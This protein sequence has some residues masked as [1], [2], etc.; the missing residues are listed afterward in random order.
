MD[1]KV[2]AGKYRVER[3]LSQEQAGRTYLTD[4]PDGSRA[5]VKVVRPADAA[6]AAAIEKDV[7]LIAGIRHPALPAVYEWGHDGADFFVVREYVPGADLELER[8]QQGSFAPLTAA[9]YGVEASDA[10][11]QIHRRGLV[12]GNVKAANIIR[13]P[14]DEI[15]LV[16]NSLGAVSAAS[17]PPGAPPSA[18]YYLAPEQVEGGGAPTPATDVYA[19]GV[20]LYELIAGHVPFDGETAAVVADKQAHEA[21][22]PIG[23]VADDVPPALE[24]VIM[25]A[26]E[27]SPQARYADGEALKVA[28]HDVIEP[29]VVVASAGPLPPRKRSVWPWVIAGAVVVIAAL[30][31]AWA[32]GAFGAHEVAIPDVVGMPRAGATA[33]ITAAGLQVGNITFSGG[34]V[35][36]VADGAVSVET[37]L[38]GT[39]VD[40]A[41]KVDLVLAGAESVTVPDVIGLTEAQATAQLQNAGLVSGTISMT[42]TSAVAAGQ[43]TSQSP[44]AGAAA[45][46][47]ASV[48]LTIAQSPSTPVVPDVTNR[49][50]ASAESILQAAGFTVR[51]VLNSNAS[52]ASGR[53]IDQDPTAGVNAQT[54]A[55]VTIVVSTGP[56]TVRVPN[57]VGM[58][59]AAAV[60]ALTAAGFKSQITLQTGGGTVGDVVDQS[61]LA[62]RRAVA[63]STVTITVVQ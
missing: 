47:G 18:A 55:T 25:R 37:P 5:I 27:K 43:V 58:T 41:T 39:R 61:P 16:G 40:P 8:G 24:A 12:H 23:G 19:M 35:P 21:P 31:L 11:A 10:L 53:V 38:A 57:V 9:R 49:T 20:V 2:F 46:K 4:G 22:A 36:G 29:P 26:L 59:Q 54:G 45:V 17:L 15:K 60:N 3:E 33:S 6:A 30:V 42:P 51:V 56:G 62:G 44:S 48:A 13:T 52:V 32:L 1:A 28:L 63:G 14:E 7:A 50:R 34:S